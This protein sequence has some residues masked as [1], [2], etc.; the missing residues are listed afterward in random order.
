MVSKVALALEPS[1]SP[2]KLNYRDFSVATGVKSLSSV[3]SVVV[4]SPL[5]MSGMGDVGAA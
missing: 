4:Y 1:Y 3:K 5:S 2:A